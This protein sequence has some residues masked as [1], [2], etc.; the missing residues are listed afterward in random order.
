MNGHYFQ[1]TPSLD[2]SAERDHLADGCESPNCEL[3]WE[4]PGNISLS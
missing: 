4:I 1:L 3:K 2:S